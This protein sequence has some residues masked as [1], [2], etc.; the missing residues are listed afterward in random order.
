[1]K[2][3]LGYISLFATTITKKLLFLNCLQK[4]NGNIKKKERTL[5]E[6]FISLQ[7][8]IIIPKLH[9]KID[10]ITKF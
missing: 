3:F 9:F 4:K 1:L 2:N 5:Q 10:S 7:S 8:V 6:F